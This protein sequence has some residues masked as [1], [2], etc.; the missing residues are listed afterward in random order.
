[1]QARTA[2]RGGGYSAR[3]D[4]GGVEDTEPGPQGAGSGLAGCPASRT[5][6]RSQPLPPS[7]ETASPLRGLEGSGRNPTGLFSPPQNR[8]PEFPEKTASAPRGSERGGS[9]VSPGFSSCVTLY[10]S[11]NFSDPVSQLLKTDVCLATLGGL[12]E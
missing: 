8:G 12:R 6:M 1:M 11:F 7:W 9:A 10:K 4:G 5:Y 2:R 3:K